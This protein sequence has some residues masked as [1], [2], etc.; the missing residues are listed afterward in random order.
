MQYKRWPSFTG[1]EAAWDQIQ[2]TFV[3]DL[4]IEKCPYLDDKSIISMQDF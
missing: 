3:F 2:R 1:T 4:N